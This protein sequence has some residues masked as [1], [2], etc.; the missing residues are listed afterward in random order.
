MK[1]PEESILRQAANLLFP[2]GAHRRARKLECINRQ[3]SEENAR[4]VKSCGEWPAGHFYSPIPSESDIRRGLD[5]AD[6]RLTF[7]GID[8]RTEEQRALLEQ[9]AKHYP[10]LEFPVSR[11]PGYRF[12]L[13]NPSYGQFDAILFACMVLHF[14]PRRI[15]EV[16]SGF[17]SALMLDLNDRF[18]GGEIE[19]TFI[20]PYPDRL[21]TLLR[22]GDLEA[23]RL[24]EC[25]VQDAPIELFRELGDGD[26]LFVDSSHVSKVGSDVNH[27]FFE[28]LPIL[29]PGV[30]VHIH[31]VSGN[32][33]YPE[34][35]LAVG[36][37]WNE[38]YL[39]R[40]FMMHN[41]AYEVR[42]HSTQM[43]E[44]NQAFFREKMPLCMEGGGG[45]FWI[46][47]TNVD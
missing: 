27:I 35:W 47:R 5:L 6:G 19:L 20:E 28:V 33:E 41:S 40:A 42:A 44:L 22:P 30:L 12:Y 7:K 32:F 15:I 4:L 29:A 2:W 23:A 38:M 46:Q 9:L 24:I 45:Q 13:D 14:K 16:G 43:R 36:R 3:L 21:R 11:D 31:D 18:A 39:L 37:A 25:E 1:P 17:S 26:I 34:D 8:Q 10:R